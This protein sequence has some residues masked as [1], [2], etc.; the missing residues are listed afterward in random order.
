MLRFGLF[1][2]LISLLLAFSFSCSRS[3]E[4]VARVGKE[5]ISNTE[6]REALRIRYP[7]QLADGI[8]LQE[9]KEVLNFLMEKR[10]KF[11]EAKDRGMDKSVEFTGAL[12]RRKERLITARLSELLITN[13]LVPEDMAQAYLWLKWNKTDVIIMGIGY[14]GSQYI[15]ASR[16]KHEAI[17]LAEQYYH[18]IKYGTDASI[19]AE[20]YSD[21]PF[22]KQNRG[23]FKPY[24]PGLF[25]PAVD[26]AIYHARENSVLEPVITGRGIFIIKVL[27]KQEIH[28]DFASLADIN[29]TRRNIYQNFFRQ[30]GDSI[31]QQISLDLRKKL[32]TEISESG[33]EQFLSAIADWSAN[34][35]ANDS[36]FNEKQRSIYLGKVENIT[37]TTGYFID[38]FQGTFSSSYQRFNDPQQLR[39]VI[40]DYIN[41]Y[42]VWLI[43]G[44]KKRL[45][46]DAEIK[47]LV[48][49]L[50]ID[51]L[52]TMFDQNVLILQSQPAEEEMEAYFKEHGEEYKESPKIELW[53]MAFK[54]EGTARKVADRARRQPEQFDKMVG[55]Y[56]ENHNSRKSY[57]YLGYVSMKS[58]REVVK[59]A[60]EIGA[61]SIIGPVFENKHYYVL[62]TGNLQPERQKEL[63]EVKNIIRAK[64]QQDK[65]EQL[66]EKI[67]KE[68]QR[69]HLYWINEKELQ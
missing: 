24:E 7:F 41:N 56:V 8:P 14:E 19:L 12:K 62:K 31:Y 4:T 63:S 50:E 29:R 46:D 67:L 34:P 21:D 13:K 51:H 16:S 27:K 42:L 43:E 33:I 2:V 32:D 69:N 53:Q 30:T 17:T 44:R 52:V 47:R 45:E 54:E 55:Q 59:K 1:S 5:K 37:L 18:D 25:D 61:H 64:I 20:N 35:G 26:V 6:F 15:T 60:F 22:I 57:R 68:F 40:D 49:Q 23:K 38:E 3:P 65:K 10:V 58:P 39:K 11:L 9:K 36:T 28:R 66:W 48:K